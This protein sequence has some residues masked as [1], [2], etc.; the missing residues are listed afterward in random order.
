MT[1]PQTEAAGR[2]FVSLQEESQLLGS[3][4]RVHD[5][6]RATSDRA[7]SVGGLRSWCMSKLP[8]TRSR[9]GS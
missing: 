9:K 3:R 8:Q 5:R 4:Q 7:R 6:I 1:V 2:N